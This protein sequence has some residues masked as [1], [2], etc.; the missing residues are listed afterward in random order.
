MVESAAE[1]G[2][3]GELA[4][5]APAAAASVDLA[6]LALDCSCFFVKSKLSGFD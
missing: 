1:L 2:E 6:L 5:R 4:E 3:L